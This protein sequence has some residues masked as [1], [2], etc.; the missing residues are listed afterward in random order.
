MARR[1]AQFGHRPRVAP[2]LSGSIADMI[3]AYQNQ[4]ESNIVEAWQKGGSF[5]GKK[6]TDTML[7]AFYQDKVDNLAPADPV[8]DE[9]KNNLE[10]YGFAVRS[11]KME[12]RYARKG[13]NDF[14]MSS[15][16]RTEANKHP[17]NS[18]IYR[19]LMTLSAQYAERGRAATAMGSGGRAA[20]ARALSA[21]VDKRKPTELA[22][23]VISQTIL[24]LARQRGILTSTQDLGDL[25]VGQNDLGSLSNLIDEFATSPVYAGWRDQLT[26]YIR[27]NGDPHFDGNFTLQGMQSMRKDKVEAL[28]SRLLLARKQGTK[29]QINDLNKNLGAA[30]G[31]GSQLNLIDPL[32]KYEE[33]Y[34]VYEL[35]MNDPNATV[36]DKWQAKE[37]YRTQV[38]DIAAT[39]AANGQANFNINTGVSSDAGVTSALAGKMFAEAD[40]LGGNCTVKTSTVHEDTRGGG[41]GLGQGPGPDNSENNVAEQNSAAMVQDIQ[42]LISRDAKGMP[43]YVMAKKTDGEWG[44][45]SV[46]DLRAS[47]APVALLPAHNTGSVTVYGTTVSVAGVV[48]AVVGEPVFAQSGGGTD[49]QGPTVN[50]KPLPGSHN[51]I[52]TIYT[53]P[54]THATLYGYF[55]AQG[56]Q[57]YSADAPLAD[58]VELRKGPS[59]WVAVL[60]RPDQGVP[61]PAKSGSKGGFFDPKEL[62]GVSFTDPTAAAASKHTVFDSTYIGFM[63]A[64]PQS[65][66]L[67]MMD[68]PESVAVAMM[69][70]A[71]GDQVRYAQLMDEADQAKVTDLESIGPAGFDQAWLANL[72]PAEKALMPKASAAAEVMSQRAFQYGQASPG[73]SLGA[74]PEDTRDIA[75]YRGRAHAILENAGIRADIS[76]MAPSELAAYVREKTGK[77]IGQVTKVPGMERFGPVDALPSNGV[78]NPYGPPRPDVNVHPQTPA[79]PAAPLGTRAGVPPAQL[80]PPPPAQPNPNPYGPPR[81]DVPPPPPPPPIYSGGLIVANPPPPPPPPPPNPP[82]MGGH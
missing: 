67:S 74:P 80:P 36:F 32:A 72:T 66:R 24:E 12:L 23:D 63:M 68:N 16:Y 1:A 38:L 75:F 31:F 29:T 33:D 26:A 81:P 51:Q 25:Q 79:I 39:I 71:K 69:T 55:D 18:E 76:R 7:L 30:S 11:S 14:G 65:R 17:K 62:L 45:M 57:R 59:G 8:Y 82:G 47:G 42:K 19:Q 56:H 77:I 52:M 49:V 34:R 13:V 5:E 50:L 28:H 44:A 64:T 46:A 60:N 48:R 43:L 27:K 9:A 73:T 35:V 78:G 4:R 22:Y 53:D 41:P 20:R 6:V 3:R 15:F 61:D 37:T 58:G 2:D 40:C 54:I 10:Q 21:E 70:E